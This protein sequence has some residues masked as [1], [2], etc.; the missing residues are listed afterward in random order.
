MDGDTM[1][2]KMILRCEWMCL[3]VK[4]ESMN[5]FVISGDNNNGYPPCKLN[6]F[7]FGKDLSFST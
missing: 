3:L 6:G 2:E 5:D 1:S 7:T 4:H